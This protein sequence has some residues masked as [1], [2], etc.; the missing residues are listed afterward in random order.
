MG[1]ATAAVASFIALACED[2][3]HR[4]TSPEQALEASGG[5]CEAAPGKLP[6]ATCD[7]S[8]KVC[9]GSGGCTIDEARCGSASTCLPIGDNKSKD[10]LDF[11][12]RRL[13]IAAPAALAADFIQNTVVTLNIDMNEK[14]C[15][16]VG[17]G[18]FSWL[19]RV[20]KSSNT[21]ITG[22]APPPTDAFGK[23]YCFANFELG[24][25]KVEPLHTKIEFSGNTF[26]SLE[27]APLKIPIFLSPEVA[28]VILLPLTDVIIENVTISDDGNCIG[29]F[30]P[31]A[32]DPACFD[33]HS[34]CSKW[35][36]SG[37]LGGYITLEEADSVLIRDIGNK[38]LCSF[39]AAETALKCPRDANGKI[40]FQGDFCSV[41]KQPGGCG[42]S[43][44]LAATFAASAAKIFDG[45]GTA[46]CSGESTRTDAGADAGDTKD[47]GSDAGDGG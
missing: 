7:N 8:E 46:G 17:K 47:A 9:T 45:Q 38:S 3:P 42:D 30:N 16:E 24:A 14:S 15:G 6:E 5:A 27:K 25:N 41:D 43:V 26:R 18:L 2:D 22:G 44:W 10:V 13:N 23:G 1:I 37:S 29:G 34:L 12:I 39:L 36:T 4:R 19:L 32:L 40:V 11:R 21:L 20:D 31:T 35:N 28:S 33:D